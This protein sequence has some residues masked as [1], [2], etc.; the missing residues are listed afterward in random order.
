MKPWYFQLRLFGAEILGLYTNI[1]TQNGK[2]IFGIRF[3]DVL[4]WGLCKNEQHYFTDFTCL[5]WP[6][7]SAE[8]K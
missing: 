7:S 3:M 5:L 6:N 8:V 4:I 1:P 2:T